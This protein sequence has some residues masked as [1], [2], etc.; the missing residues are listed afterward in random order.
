MRKPLRSG[1]AKFVAAATATL[2]AAGPALAQDS[3]YDLEKSGWYIRTGTYI[4]M[5][6]KMSVSRTGPPVAAAPGIYDNGFVQPDIGQGAQGLTWNW[7]YTDKDQVTSGQLQYSRV[8]NLATVGSLNGFKDPSLFGPE[9]LVG[10]DFYQFE[11]LRK[12]AHFGFEL[13]FRQGRYSGSDQASVGSDVVQQRDAY[14]LGG[15]T[16][17]LAPYSGYFAVPGPLIST[18][19]QPLAPVASRATSSLATSFAADFYTARFGAW[20]TYP[21][22]QKW[23]LEASL[24]FTSIYAQGNATFIQNTTYTNPAILSTLQSAQTSSGDWL[25][26]GYMQV[27][28]EYRVLPWLGIYAGLEVAY[29]GAFRLN[30]LGYEAKFDFG[31]NYGGSAGLQFSF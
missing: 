6:M 15:I 27:R 8:D 2:T 26:G 21:L 18:N 11:M 25:P 24:G 23:D 9:I 22:T 1:T 16:P 19:P 29:N 3:P 14:D 10:F 30:G 20:L 12:D 28:G 17:P 5:G 31:A 13:G 7:G 4:Q